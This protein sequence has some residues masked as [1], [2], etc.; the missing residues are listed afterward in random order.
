MVF[1]LIKINQQM[2]LDIKKQKK[3]FSLSVYS[4]HILFQIGKD[5]F[6]QRELDVFFYFFSC[7]FISTNVSVLDFKS[8]RKRFLLFLDV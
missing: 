6:Y 7:I 1:T 3:S 2:I 8:P 5:R 4:F